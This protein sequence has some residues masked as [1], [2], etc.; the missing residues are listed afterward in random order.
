MEKMPLIPVSWGEVIDKIT[1]LEIKERRISGEPALRNIVNELAALREIVD[2]QGDALDVIAQL[3][4]R[5]R[6][7]NLRLW[8]VE[9]AIRLKERDGTFDAEFVQLARS[10]YL[11]NDQRSA[12]K[13][14]INRVTGSA[15][16]E[17]KSYS[18]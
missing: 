16:F 6:E 13:R 3:V 9:D 14:E 4:D 12:I 11:K 17:E 7:V 18:N 1:I 5:L 15:L 8:D 2:A 10:V